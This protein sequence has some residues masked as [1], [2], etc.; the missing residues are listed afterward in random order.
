MVTTFEDLEK[1]VALDKQE[2]MATEKGTNVLE[3]LSEAE[4]SELPAGIGKVPRPDSNWL[5]GFLTKFFGRQ[6]DPEKVQEVLAKM[7]DEP[8][9]WSG[10]PEDGWPE[11]APVKGRKTELPKW[12]Q[13]MLAP[14]APASVLFEPSKEDFLRYQ[15]VETRPPNYLEKILK[16]W[17]K[18]MK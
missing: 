13:F 16:E 9:T 1:S 11:G 18:T 10:V 15:N 8:D 14:D 2:K 3:Q 12:M 6:P 5:T 4:L 17:L 7:R